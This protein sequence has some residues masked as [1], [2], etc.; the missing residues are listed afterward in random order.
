MPILET[1]KVELSLKDHVQY[2]LMV[3]NIDPARQT[4]WLMAAKESECY[5]RVFA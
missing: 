4:I 2:L 3:E 1:E 5:D